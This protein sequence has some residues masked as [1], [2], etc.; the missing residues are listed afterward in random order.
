MRPPAEGSRTRRCLSEVVLG[1]LHVEAQ[2]HL[3]EHSDPDQ[4][5]LLSAQFQ[6]IGLAGTVTSEPVPQCTDHRE[7]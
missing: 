1:D 5:A 4:G 7:R 3:G 2:S 6:A